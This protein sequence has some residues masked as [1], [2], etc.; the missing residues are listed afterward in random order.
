MSRQTIAVD[1]DDVIADGTT[2]LREVVN[3]YTGAQLTKEHYSVPGDYWGYY[4]R[5]WHEHGLEVDF[6]A[7]NTEMAIDQSHVPILPGAIFAVTELSKRYDLVVITARDPS[8][9]QATL[10]WLDKNCPDIFKRILFAGKSQETSK[11]KGELCV[12]L[13]ASWLIDDNVDHCLSAV[14]LGIEAILF[15]EYGWHHKA[16]KDLTICK[17][18]PAVLEYFDGQN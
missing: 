10:T 6:E 8:W 11:T 16:P 13:G 5:V 17:D 3:T 4:E 1:I 15:G 12:E 14:E 7:L 2:S 18:W 9:E